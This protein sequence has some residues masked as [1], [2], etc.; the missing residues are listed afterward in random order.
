MEGKAQWKFALSHTRNEAGSIQRVQI[1]VRANPIEVDT[2]Q[3]A[4]PQTVD[5]EFH[6]PQG[7][8]L[9][10][11]RTPGKKQENSQ[12]GR[13]ETCKA[14]HDLTE[15][16]G[17][18]RA[19]ADGAHQSEWRS[20]VSAPVTYV[21]QLKTSYPYTLILSPSQTPTVLPHPISVFAHNIRSAHNVGSIFRTADSA[22]LA[23]VYLTGFTATPEHRGVRKTALGAEATVPWSHN[24]DPLALLDRLKSEG[25]K[26]VALERTEV[27]RRI[28]EVEGVDFPMALILGNEV[29]GVPAALLDAADI[30]LALP[31][32]GVKDSLNVSVAFG[33]AAY[34]LVGQYRSL[35]D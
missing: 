23:H 17:R 27:A 35:D 21:N 10:N 18:G 11:S 31:Q 16:G 14:R 32:Y 20:G 22:G 4:I 19:M 9:L 33:I 12:K 2:S 34:G 1:I 8:E 3:Q 28:E 5:V 30:T 26:I 24:E 6:L 29:T 15:G 13:K 25:T 7:S